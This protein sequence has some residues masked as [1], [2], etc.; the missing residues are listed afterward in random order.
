LQTKPKLNYQ[1]TTYIEDLPYIPLK[2]Q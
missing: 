2:K 1:K